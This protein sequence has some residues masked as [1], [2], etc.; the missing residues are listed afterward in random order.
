MIIKRIMGSMVGAVVILAT[1]LA[2]INAS[3]SECIRAAEDA[4]LPDEAIDQLKNPGEL[5]AVERLVL[6]RALDKAGVGDAC[7]EIAGEL[8]GD[9]EGSQLSRLDQ[10]PN[11]HEPAET[12]DQP[13]PTAELSA[14]IP[15]DDEHRRRCRF[16]ALNNLQPIVF[17]EFAKLDPDNMD[18]LDRILWRSQLHPH[19]HL[20]FYDDDNAK[21]VDIPALQPKDPGIYCRDYW[22]EPLG[23]GNADLRNHG[24]ETQCRRRLEERI[25]NRYSQ[26]A[27]AVNYEEDHDLVYETANQYVRVLQWLGMSGEGPPGSQQTPLHNPPGAEQVS[28][29]PHRGPGSQRGF[30][31][32][33]PE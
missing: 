8:G 27:D 4:G 23:S 10:E 7:G 21:G 31:G 11:D 3:P 1:T 30:H 5:N 22:A 16:W 29:R 26:L 20:G 12:E 13:T 18:D 19:D 28:L 2:C 24:F 9:Q 25:I 32:R 15:E 6:N 33:L 17:E 14:R